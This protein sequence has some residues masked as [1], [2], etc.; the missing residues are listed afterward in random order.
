MKT[1]TVAQTGLLLDQLLWRAYG[2][3]GTTSAMLAAALALNPGLA[4]AGPV[5]AP[6]TTVR[7]PDLPAPS[8]ASARKVVNLFD[9]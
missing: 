2:R 3:A 8:A 9:D 7:L 5:I 1:V 4:A 6:G